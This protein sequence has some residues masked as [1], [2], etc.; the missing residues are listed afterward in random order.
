MLLKK[1]FPKKP[2]A[3]NWTVHILNQ[4]P[5]LAVKNMTPKEAWNGINPLVEHFQ[6]FGCISQVHV[7]DIKITKL[8]DKSFTCVL[9]GVS[10]ESKAYRLYD[11]VARKIIVSRDVIFE[12][13]KS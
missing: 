8:E 12:E 7:V 6:V 3:I 2:E 9:L 13:N 10:E 11:P 4:S 5:T 1:K